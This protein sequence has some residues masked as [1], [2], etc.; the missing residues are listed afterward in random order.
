MLGIVAVWITQKFRQT[1]ANCTEFLSQCVV[2]NGVVVVV[3]G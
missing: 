3:V 1:M 2:A